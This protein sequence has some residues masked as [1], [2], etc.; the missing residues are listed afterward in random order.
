MYMRV[1]CCEVTFRV[2]TSS[3]SAVIGRN[4]ISSTL[5]GAAI[6]G[7]RLRTIGRFGGS[8]SVTPGGTGSKCSAGATSFPGRILWSASIARC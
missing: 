4:A 2:R 3:D 8:S 1:S 5:L 6:T 7:T